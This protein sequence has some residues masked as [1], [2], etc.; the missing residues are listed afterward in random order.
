MYGWK[1]DNETFRLYLGATPDQPVEGMFSFV[2][3]RAVGA[4]VAFARPLLEFSDVIKPNLRMQARVIQMP[5]P[6]IEQVW[7]EVV[8]QITTANLAL[9]TQLRLP[10]N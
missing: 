2:P 7:Q 1:E 6:E 8:A 4:E 5:L 9:A 3:C 10:S